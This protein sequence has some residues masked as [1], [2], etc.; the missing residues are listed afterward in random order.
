[1]RS[2]QAL[3]RLFAVALIVS[4][5]ILLPVGVTLAEEAPAETASSEQ[6]DDQSSSLL[7]DAVEWLIEMFSP[8]DTER[9][10]KID[11]MG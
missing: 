10:P 6:K 2:F 4:A 1:M 7:N 11:P 8:H 9:G 3:H 5:L